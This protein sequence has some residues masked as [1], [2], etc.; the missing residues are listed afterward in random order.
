MLHILLV[1]VYFIIEKNIGNFSSWKFVLSFPPSLLRVNNFLIL[2]F[3]VSYGKE[4]VTD[5]PATSWFQVFIKT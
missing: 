3:D 2:L 4:D 5:K 1:K